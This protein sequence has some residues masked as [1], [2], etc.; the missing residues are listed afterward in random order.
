[1]ARAYS[2]TSCSKIRRVFRLLGISV[3]GMAVGYRGYL[4]GGAMEQIFAAWEGSDQ[5]EWVLGTS[6]NRIDAVSRDGAL[7]LSS[8]NQYYKD[9]MTVPK[10]SALTDKS[11][12]NPNYKSNQIISKNTTANNATAR[13]GRKIYVKRR[14][15]FVQPG[16]WDGTPIVM[17][18]HK[19][20][21]LTTP[22]VSCTV[23]KMLFRRMMGYDD[24]KSQDNTLPHNPRLNGLK[25]L[26][27]YS[28]PQ[29]NEM[30]NA[31]DWTKAVFVREPKER[32]L[33]SYLDKTRAS[34]NWYL[35]KYCCQLFHLSND[36]PG[37]GSYTHLQDQSAPIMSF[38]TFLQEVVPKC[39]DNHWAPQ[40]NQL[41]KQVWPFFTF[42]GHFDSIYEDT[43]RLLQ[44]LLSNESGKTAWEEFGT[45]GWG[46]H[47][48]VS[49]FDPAASDVFV[50]HGTGARERLS[51]L[52]TSKADSLV[53]KYYV[54]DF[55]F[56]R[57]G[58]VR[59]SLA[60][61]S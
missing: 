7:A 44:Q 16:R 46:P 38:E 34:N 10:I 5:E 25:Y 39:L 2:T 47:S 9:M 18:S 23:F 36:T 56:E 32:I 52:Y 3:L 50:T 61:Q 59:R 20:I 40:Y 24:W 57:F 19:L 54:D 42:I 15:N 6:S 48:N 11:E 53:E 55:D 37:C 31:P 17:E 29:I 43:K 1:M 14:D 12:Q 21:F 4:V 28:F 35:Q 27:Q 49:I 8:S 30:I 60:L 26:H 33:S 58:F 22:K 13:I 51:E 41:P 45:T